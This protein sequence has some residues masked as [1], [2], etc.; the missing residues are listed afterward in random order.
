MRKCRICGFPRRFT[1]FIEWNSDG[2]M[3]GRIRPR[4]PVMLL[5]VS[6]WDSIFYELSSTLGIPIDHI[7]IDAQKNI[8]KG[9]YET[10]RVTHLSYDIK[11]LPARWYFRPQW[12]A[13][14]FVWTIRNDLAGLG[15]GR[16]KLVSYHSGKDAL[17]RMS[18]PCLNPMIVGNCQGIYESAEKMPGSNAEYRLENGDLVIHLTHASE[19][20]GSEERLYL[21]EV[22]PGTGPLVYER[23]SHCNVPVQFARSVSWDIPRGIISNPISGERLEFMAVQSVNAILR[24]LENELGEEIVHI[25]YDAQ[26]RFSLGRL[27]GTSVEDPEAFWDAYLLEM[28]LSGLGY[29]ERFDRTG[30]SIS[31]EI[32]NAYNQDLYA[33]KLAAGFEKVTGRGP[34]IHWEQRDRHYGIYTITT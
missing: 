2:T 17:I 12:G 27:G 8:G 6:E 24:E 32:L 1:R 29:P 15:A 11:K 7:L 31:V 9:I 34:Q 18:D 5:E 30:D 20:G 33:A 4:I 25:L 19:R 14:L 21:E 3:I 28:A 13:K 10:V 16:V 23:C 26:K 22:V